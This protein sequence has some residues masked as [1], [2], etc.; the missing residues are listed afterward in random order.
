MRSRRRPTAI[1]LGVSA[2]LVSAAPVFALSGNGPPGDIV[3]AIPVLAVFAIIA[4]LTTLSA[5]SE[6]R[7]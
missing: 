3:D 7:R 1:L 6:A 2:A 4:I 5:I